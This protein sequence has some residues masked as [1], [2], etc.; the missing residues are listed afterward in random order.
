MTYLW[1]FPITAFPNEQLQMYQDRAQTLAAL[2]EVHPDWT[3][4]KV[5]NTSASDMV[6]R[7]RAF[8]PLQESAQRT[9]TLP[10]L[11]RYMESLERV[12]EILEA[13]KRA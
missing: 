8:K 10:R 5:R 11:K 4:L 9:K 12:L 2:I 13:L 1:R 3:R 7:V 6:K